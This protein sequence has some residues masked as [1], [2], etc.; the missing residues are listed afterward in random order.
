MIVSDVMRPNCLLL[1]PGHS[2]REASNL[3]RQQGIDAAPVINDRDRLLGVIN[4]DL[5]LEA[6][7]KGIDLETS[8]N[9]VMI[10]QPRTIAVTQELNDDLIDRLYYRPVLN[11][12]Q[13]VGM[14]Y[15]A[16]LDRFKAFQLKEDKEEMEAAL[17]AVYNPVIQVDNDGRINLFNRAASKV[18]GI[19]QDKARGA[20]ACEVLGGSRVLDHLL[21]ADRGPVFANK[22][23]LNNR[24]FLPYRTDVKKNGKVIGAV[25]V[26]R[27]ISEF[28]ELVRESEYYKNLNK[29]MDAII[30]SSFDGLYVTDGKANTLRLNKGFER[31][32][33]ITQEQCIGRN[34]ADLVREGVFS[35]SGTLMALDKRERV[36]ITLVASTG[37]EALV[38]SNPIFDEYGNII[39]VVTNV[40]DITE[41][42]GLQRKLEHIDSLRQ[43]YESELQQLKLQKSREMVLT[44]NKMKEL[45]NMVL[46]IA[47]VDSTVLIQGESGVG[48]ELIA[49]IIHSNSNR[50]NGPYI[51][52]NCGAI[53]ENLLESELFGYD[54]GAFTGASKGGKIGLFE[55]ASGGVLFLDEIGE[56]PLNLQVKLLRVLQDREINRVGGTQPIKVDIRILAG[57]NRNL[58]DMVANNRFRLD[59]YYRLN[60]IPVNVPPL[61]ERKED[62]PVLA[63]YYLNMF[64][65]KYGM[66]RRLHRGVLDCLYDYDWPGNVRELENLLEQLIVTGMHEVIILEDLPATF[67][68]KTPMNTGSQELLPLKEALENTERQLLE[69]AFICCKS[70]YKIAEALGINQSTVVRKAAKY[71]I[72]KH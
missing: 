49:E 40:R 64:N 35:R 23:I 37:K 12:D 4:K 5:I 50:K 24:S 31:V 15:P 30:E 56:M 57:T 59:L 3:F 17:D 32:M 8:V 66:N 70:T 16:D 21:R 19:D 60:V 20:N 65:L 51:K 38:T 67:S 47:A 26:L 33:G 72:A 9:Q 62:I 42:N 28:E 27:E 52:V 48:K 68:P 18:L 25:L 29:E 11:G 63:N 1:Y 36:T 10:T 14:L 13:V 44:S 7:E 55:L 54:A 43:F 45:V 71:G 53:P 2:L 58:L 41:L 34:M 6:I 61:R 46:R 69:K 22:L 39:L